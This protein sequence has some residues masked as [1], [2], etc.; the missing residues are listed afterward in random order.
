MADNC[1]TCPHCGAPLPAEASFCPRCAQSVNR[2]RTLSPPSRGGR[3]TLR[4]IMPV[5]VLLLFLGGG[6]LWVWAAR[7]QVYEGTGEVTY[8]LSGVPYRLFLTNSAEH[9]E[10]L[11][12]REISTAVS[13]E[14]YRAPV[15]LYIDGGAGGAAFLEQVERVTAEFPTVAGRGGNF[16]CTAPS[17]HSAFPGIPLVSLMDYTVSTDCT[18]QMTW[19]FTMKNGDTI[20]LRQEV[21]VSTAR[22]YD[23]YPTDAPMSTAAELQAL[24]DELADTLEPDAE[25]NLHLPAVTYEAVPITASRSFNFYGST[26]GE[27]RTT[28]TAPLRLEAGAVDWISYLYDISFQGPGSGTALSAVAEQS[29]DLLAVF[30]ADFDQAVAA[31]VPDSGAAAPNVELYYNAASTASQSTYMMFTSLLDTYEAQLAN[32]FD[33]NAGAERYDL[34]T[35]EDAAGAYF[36]MLLPMLL[37]IFLYSGCAAVA[38]ESIAGEKERGTIATMLITPIPRGH[39]AVGK[40]LAL[41][42]IALLSGASSTIGTILALPKLMGAASDSLS[43][44]I[45]SVGDYLLLA[46]VILSTV[47]LLVTLISILSAFAKTVKEAQTYATPLMI[48]VMLLGVTGMFGGG[49]SQDLPAY[50]IPLYNSVQCMVGVFSFTTFTAGVAATLAVNGVCTILGV[51]VLARMFNS[52]KII[53]AR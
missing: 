53:F 47:L 37:M 4:R 28:F 1:K 3:R 44:D 21:A 25:I 31:Y 5:L 46:A 6:T 40:I 18:A 41:A 52:E 34:T 16:S 36:A 19:T 45:Y 43:A 24:L 2:R 22:T 50:L 27:Q 13:G 17:P 11:P 38:P 35:E 32:K 14:P 51:V 23:Y 49:A 26:Q 10:P 20:R 39:I 48:L 9:P 7:P 12:R 30:P 33:V 29:L 15:L 8:P 42:V